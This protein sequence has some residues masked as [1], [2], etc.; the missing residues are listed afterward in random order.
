MQYALHVKVLSPQTL[1]ESVRND[2]KAAMM[3]YEES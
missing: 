1:V 3:N 2:L